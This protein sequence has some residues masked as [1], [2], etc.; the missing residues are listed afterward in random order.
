M[1]LRR[2]P[3]ARRLVSS[4]AAVYWRRASASLVSRSSTARSLGL[5]LAALTIRATTIP[6]AGHHL[7]LACRC[8]RD[9]REPRAVV[10]VRI[11]REDVAGRL[12]GMTDREIHLAGSV[13]LPRGGAGVLEEHLEQLRRVRDIQKR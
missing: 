5:A 6:L 12:V 1:L 7:V 8:V 13:F 3:R 11:G 2:R 10:P 9:A 4:S